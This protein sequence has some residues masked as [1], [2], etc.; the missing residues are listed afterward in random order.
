VRDTDHR[1]HDLEYERSVHVVSSQ[2]PGLRPALG[3][4]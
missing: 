1:E 2:G 4:V 3:V